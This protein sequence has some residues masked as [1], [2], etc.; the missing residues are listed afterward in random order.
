MTE[1]KGWSLQSRKELLIKMAAREK[2][3]TTLIAQRIFPHVDSA[4]L[5]WERPCRFD[6]S[7]NSL[8]GYL[9]VLRGAIN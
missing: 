9:I 6:T 7:K 5:I 8:I 3:T 2:L 4:L 1:E